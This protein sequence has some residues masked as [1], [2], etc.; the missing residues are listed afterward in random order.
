MVDD[1]GKIFMECMEGRNFI[2]GVVGVVSTNTDC[3]SMNIINLF[4]SK[5]SAQQRR[6]IARYVADI[7]MWVV[8]DHCIWL[9][10]NHLHN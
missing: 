6:C 10:K 9:K 3:N 7:G 1:V 4:K 5:R 2:E 8:P